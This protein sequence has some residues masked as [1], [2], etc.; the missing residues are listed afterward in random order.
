[1]I[2]ESARTAVKASTDA[3]V[4]SFRQ[5]VEERY[6][7]W[8]SSLCY[9]LGIEPPYAIV[10]PGALA[11]LVAGVVF[12]VTATGRMILGSGKVWTLHGILG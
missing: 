6:R 12:D 10:S 9:E 5:G 3:T 4:G 11:L 8:A 7:P 1:M 2:E